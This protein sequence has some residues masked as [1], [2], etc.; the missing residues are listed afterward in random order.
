MGKSLG[1]ESRSRTRNLRD[2]A[3]LSWLAQIRGASE[4]EARG[5]MRS[6]ELQRPP[7]RRCFLGG[8]LINKIDNELERRAR[9]AMNSYVPWA[10]VVEEP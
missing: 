4:D 2:D 9:H 10:G 5:L 7:L 1:G 3:R 6:A 8:R